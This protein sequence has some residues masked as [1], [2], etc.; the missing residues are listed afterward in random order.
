MKGQIVM[1]RLDGAAP[2]DYFADVLEFGGAPGAQLRA[3]LNRGELSAIVPAGT[4]KERILQFEVGGLLPAEPKRLLGDKWV[5]PTPTTVP[6]LAKLVA[7]RV[8]LFEDMVLWAHEPMLNEDELNSFIGEKI[9]AGSVSCQRID[10]Q[11]YLMYQ[12]GI[13]SEHKIADAINASMLSWHFLAFVTDRLHQPTSVTDLLKAA[14]MILV[15]A[16]DGESA[17]IWERT[18]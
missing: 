17:L 5:Q 18:S 13:R 12:E 6:T 16:Y 1:Q 15:G 4:T 7:S 11:L 2:V 9:S 14:R 3:E 8:R 10:G